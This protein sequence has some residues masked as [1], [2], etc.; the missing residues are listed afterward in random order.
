MAQSPPQVEPVQLGM[1][2]HTGL[3][4]E[5]RVMPRLALALRLEPELQRELAPLLERAQQQRAAGLREP[6]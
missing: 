5:L 1:L 2:L 3:L 6:E 4:R